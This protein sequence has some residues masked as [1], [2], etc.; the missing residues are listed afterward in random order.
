LVAVLVRQTP[1]PSQVRAGVNVVPA[2]VDATQVVPM[3]YRRQVPEPSQ[4]PSVPHEAAPW[5]P[6]WFS[7]S[8]PAGTAVHVPT[9]PVSAHDWQV[10][11]QAVAQQKPCAQKPELHSAAAPQAAPMGF[12]PQLPVMQVLGDVQSALLAHEVLHAAV[13]QI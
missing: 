12:L 1:A 10:P 6:H 2:Q 9:L 7:G 4:K 8:W 13:P 5:S 3:A 11:V